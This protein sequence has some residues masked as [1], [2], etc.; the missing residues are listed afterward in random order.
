MPYIEWDTQLETGVA[1]ID[2]EHRRLVQLL[3]EIHELI[4]AKADSIRIA[5]T[6]ADFHTLATAHFALEEKIM[7]DQKY[8]AFARRRE[9]HRRLLDEVRDI[10]DAYDAGSYREGQSLPATLRQWLFQLMS[11]DVDLFT[12]ITP[13]ILRKWG[14]AQG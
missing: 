1:G 3:N 6:L 5:D 2:H 11:I 12:R 10:M 8:P 13:A 7:R 4:E 14:L 9:T